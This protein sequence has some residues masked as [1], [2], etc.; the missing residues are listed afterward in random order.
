MDYYS[1]RE[2][3]IQTVF[4]IEINALKDAESS[5]DFKTERSN[6][7]AVPQVNSIMQNLNCYLKIKVNEGNVFFFLFTDTS[8]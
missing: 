6:T 2:N 5:R 8:V 1:L 4:W 7:C 3:I